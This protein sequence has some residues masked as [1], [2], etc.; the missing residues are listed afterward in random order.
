M[1]LWR[2]SKDLTLDKNH[3]QICTVELEAIGGPPTVKEKR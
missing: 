3:V 1:I 2:V